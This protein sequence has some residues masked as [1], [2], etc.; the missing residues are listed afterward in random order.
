MLH[1]I[2]YPLSASCYGGGFLYH[3]PENKVAI[4][5]VVGLD[6]ADP[7]LSIFHEF[8]KLKRH[9]IVSSV[10]KGGT[11]LQYGART[12]NEGFGHLLATSGHEGRLCLGGIQCIPR[13]DF[14]GGALIGC[15]A[16]FMNSLRLKGTHGAMKSGMLAAQALMTELEQ[17]S[18]T[19]VNMSPVPDGSIRIKVFSREWR[20]PWRTIH[21]FFTTVGSLMS[22]PLSGTSDP[23]FVMDSMLDSVQ[24]FSMEHF[25]VDRSRGLLNTGRFQA[26]TMILS[27]SLCHQN[28]GS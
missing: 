2:G 14:P 13:L 19:T 1:T 8:Q 24:P 27:N 16:G 12:L 11:C 18:T 15:S 26:K 10:L 22:S 17:E 9:R 28:G 21:G 5:L 20:C 3:M 7:H 23:C 6:Y 4:G 25:S